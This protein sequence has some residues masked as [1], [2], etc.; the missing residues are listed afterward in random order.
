[1]TE[2][3]EEERKKIIGLG[4]TS[5]R[6]SYY[7]E[8]LEQIIEL[9]QKNEELQAMNQELIATEEELHKNYRALESREQELLESQARFQ[10]VLENSIVALY[11]RNYQ[12]DT[13]EYVSPAITAINGYTPE[14][15]MKRSVD[16]FYTMIHPDDRLQVIEQIRSVIMKGGGTCLLEYR[17]IHKKGQELWLK[18]ISRIVVDESGNPLYSIGSIQ[19]NTE[20]K[21]IELIAKKAQ[22]KL[23]YLNN[24]TF[25]EITNTNFALVGFI[26]LI[27]E[28]NE[29]D[30]LVSFITTVEELIR[31]S[32]T[33]LQSV[34][35]Y[36]Q[37]GTQPPKWHN[38]SLTMLIALSHLNLSHLTRTMEIEGLECYAD[39][40]LEH[41]FFIIFENI[42]DHSIQA[43][44]LSLT[45]QKYSET[46][47]LF[48]EDNGEGILEDKK[49]LIFEKTYHRSKG[50]GLFLA[51]EILSIT[52]ISIRECGEQGKGARFEL[53][54]PA[55]GYRIKARKNPDHDE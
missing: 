45:Y 11:K 54:I 19:D 7:P 43:T 51:R 33:I 46:L 13:Y 40:L 49:T 41:V 52:G 23:A 42:I 4:S 20:L 53:I 22:D 26:Q 9:K 24:V 29:D 15:T 34:K 16:A 18:D 44:H 32:D 1:M 10:D 25:Q 3:S 48:I 35:E 17:Y 36:Q 6:K 47:S 31:K 12:T 8:L 50:M 30:N 37:I 14:E 21:T 55:T 39:P 5:H 2:N 27:S 28:G 38:V